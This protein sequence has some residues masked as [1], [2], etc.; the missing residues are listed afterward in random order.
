MKT[1]TQTLLVAALLLLP[2]QAQAKVS[3]LETVAG[4]AT[5]VT[6]T[7]LPA[8][9]TVTLSVQNP[10][11]ETV[12]FSTKSDEAGTAT[13]WVSG[14]SLQLA[15][16]YAV[17]AKSGTSAMYGEIVVHPDSLDTTLSFIEADRTHLEVGNEAMVTV[18][19]ADRFG[20]PLAGRMVELISSRSED[21]V[22]ALTSETDMYGEQSFAV[23]ASTAG[24]ISL[25]AI[26]LIS[27]KTLS[28]SMH[29]MAGAGTSPIGGPEAVAYTAPRT[30][31]QF[32]RANP[33]T[34]T[35][36]Y[37]ASLLGNSLRGQAVGTPEFAGIRIQIVGQEQAST[38][39]MEQFTA[40]S[41]LLTA[42]DQY[43]NPYFDYT[44]TVYLA[45]TDP[46]ATLPLFGVYNF[47]FEDEGQKM[48]TLGLKFST[49]GLQTMVLTASPDEIPTNPQ[50]ALGYLEVN[51][52]PQQVQKPTTK[53]ITITSP[54]NGALLNASEVM[55][56]GSGPAFINIT[57]QIGDQ[58]I[59]GETD[60]QGFYALNVPL[61][62]EQ[63]EHTISV[64]DTDAPSNSA[65]VTFSIDIT[66]PAITAVTFT[67]ENPIEETDVLVVVDTEPGAQDVTL[68]LNGEDIELMNTDPGSGKYQKLLTAPVAGV[69]DATAS[70]SDNLGNT[71]TLTTSLAVGFRGLASVQNVIAEPQVN[72]ISLRWDPVTTDD[73]DAYRIYV[74]TSPDE[75]LYTLD[76]DRPTAA[77]T[78][79]GLRPGTTYYFA[80]TALQGQRE[81]EDKGDIVSATVLGVTLDVT[82]GDGSLFIEWT[83]LQQDQPLSNFLLEYGVEAESLTEQRLLNGEL[84][85]YTLRDLI[86]GV[87][88][89]LKLTPVTTTGEKLNDLAAEGQ[90]TPI[91]GGFTPGTS[92]PVPFDLRGSAPLQP[93]PRPVT[94]I[95]LSE[96]GIPSWAMWSVVIATIVIYHGYVRHR[97]K[98]NATMA[99]L[100]SMESRYHQ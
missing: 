35:N 36:P 52:T 70:A 96:Q 51:V 59:T 18:V 2:W 53:P 4:I 6:A 89:F 58:T 72:A 10:A 43:G 29:L 68:N 76:T 88:Y 91:G 23:R 16:T 34:N 8:N 55:V 78:V 71:A 47:R 81:S 5:E 83:S 65:D 84:R 45:T 17:E 7:D 60:R 13:T 90:G 97:R 25:R 19:L 28:D 24:D 62:T 39:S 99:F 50:D 92:D 66:P 1:H 86:N 27:G 30:P 94:E 3:A 87:N 22:Q 48:L 26:D 41:M 38:P 77:A 44:G 79:A 37:S 69:Y 95:P 40:E 49:P 82:P 73:I 56:E 61:N 20:N 9:S 11:N 85:A 75:F 80:V 98:Q 100:Q 67:P 33:N 64:F 31:T 32:Y 54:R 42:V 63:T 46:E 74:G 57:A 14:N 21:S 93:T 15:G 12:S